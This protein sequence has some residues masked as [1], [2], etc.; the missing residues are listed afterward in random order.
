[1]KKSDEFGPQK[2]CTH[3]PHSEVESLSS[4]PG[5]EEAIISG[6]FLD[7]GGMDSNLRR[8]KISW[9]EKDC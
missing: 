8:Q 3:P 9:L 2:N 1:M 5:F 7:P 4:D 6:C